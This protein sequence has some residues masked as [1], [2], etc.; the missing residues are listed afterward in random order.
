MEQ[1]QQKT[2]MPKK[3]CMITLMFGIESDQT[4]LN[5]KKQLD[6]IIKDIKDTR[7]NFQINEV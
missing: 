3:S 6:E 2:P 4:A 7:Y 1:P 5:I